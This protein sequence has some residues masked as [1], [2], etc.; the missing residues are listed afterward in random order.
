MFKKLIFIVALLC[1]I[2]YGGYYFGLKKGM[3]PMAMLAGAKEAYV[4]TGPVTQKDITPSKS[5]IALVE[6]INAVDISGRAKAS[7]RH[8][9]GKRQGT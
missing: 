2:G 4:L 1:G 8:P 7:C 6:P 3:A 5:F 9:A